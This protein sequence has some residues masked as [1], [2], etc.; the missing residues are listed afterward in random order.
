MSESKNSNSMIFAVLSYLY[1]LWLL[2]L[3]LAPEDGFARYHANQGLLLFI[4][5]TVGGMVLSFIP[6][7]GWMLLPFFSIA[8]FVLM[9]LG[10]INA[11]NGQTKPLPIIGNYT[12]IK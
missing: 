12:L 2:P 7:I 3:F 10:M 9:I 5:S 8:C 6:I 1:L 11:F 4:V